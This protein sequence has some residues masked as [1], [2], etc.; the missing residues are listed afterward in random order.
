MPRSGDVVRIRNVG[1]EPW[2]DSFGG[3]RYQASPGSETLAPFDAACLWFGHP[4]AVDLND[5]ESYRT[6]EYQR[7]RTRYGVYHNDDLWEP[8]TPNIEVWDLDG[9]RLVMV[10]ND[11]E[12]KH[13]TPAQTSV[14]EQQNL[15]VMVAAL[16]SQLRQVQAQLDAQTRAETATADSGPID[17]DEGPADTA[18]DLQVGADADLAD[19]PLIP[20][21]PSGPKPVDNDPSIDVM[22]D[23][24]TKVRVSR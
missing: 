10:L 21:T 14:A 1:S 8:H 6:D 3:V 7:L 23:T 4:E 11:P 9:N 13:L 19:N 22:E 15:Q 2:S 16:Q 24:P 12:G 17:T 5:R 20:G 18:V